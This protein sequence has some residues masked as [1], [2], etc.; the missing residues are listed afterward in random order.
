MLPA[1]KNSPWLFISL[2]V[3]TGLIGSFVYPLMSLFLV[4]DLDVQPIFIGVY[5]VSVTV[6]GLL[7]SQWLG[8]KADT[9]VSARKMYIFSVVAMAIGLFIY[10]NAASFW[11]V[12]AAGIAFVAVG[13]AAI[14]QM[15]TV[16]RQW[17][18]QT[19]K[20]DIAQFNAK[21]RAAISLAWM[22]G[23]AIGFALASALGFFASFY[24]S[25]VCA[26]IAAIFAFKFIPDIRANNASLNADKSQTA[27][28]PFWLLTASVTLGSVANT[29]YSSSMPLYTIRELGF[30]QYTPGLFMGLVACLEI[31]VMLLSSRLS[32]RVSKTTL[33]AI[34]YVFAMVFYVGIY[35]AEQVWQFIGLQFINAIFYGLF[36]GLTLTLL[37]Q[38][39]PQRVGFTSA[40]YSN[41]IKTGVM[42]GSTLTGFIGQFL[43]FRLANLG[44]FV[45][46]FSA[47][48]CLC[49]FVW[50]NTKR[51]R[52][53][54]AELT[55]STQAI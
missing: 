50:L 35:F 2:S 28:W 55:L 26:L 3:L 53:T 22:A 48:L 43:S 5:T 49:A 32:R 17:A 46:I 18:N 47:L 13:N 41:A 44:A 38:E 20:V 7:I 31:P 25:A 23:P 16:S 54:T 11:L 1:V 33:V 29:L 14:P 9:G 24:M 6:S 51:T 21:L 10:A 4:Q 37:Q 52:A 30:E 19:N 15:L 42:L 36:A 45:A 39:L 40:C 8:K 27:G 34:A 12:L